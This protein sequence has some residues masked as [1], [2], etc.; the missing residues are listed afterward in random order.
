MASE[1]VT[2]SMEASEAL[3]RLCNAE[4][5]L[6]LA[7]KPHDDTIIGNPQWEINEA[8]HGVRRLLEGCYSSL[9]WAL[10][11]PDREVEEA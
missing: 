2:P 1:S 5:M 10:D 11:H 6:N 8:L 7:V 3:A 4:C 9:S